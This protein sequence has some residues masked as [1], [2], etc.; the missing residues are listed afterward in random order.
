MVHPL[1]LLD[2]LD[3]SLAR[4]HPDP[5][6]PAEPMVANPH[7]GLGAMGGSAYPGLLDHPPA[8]T[9]LGEDGFGVV[10]TEPVWV[11]DAV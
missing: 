2:A 8:P 3:V 4:P 1:C 7:D 10:V 5:L 9:G 6:A 11:S